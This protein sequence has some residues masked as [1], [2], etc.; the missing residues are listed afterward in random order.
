MKSFEGYLKQTVGDTYLLLAGGGIKPLSD[1]FDTTTSDGRYVKKTGDIMTGGLAI[2]P[3]TIT[4]ANP[5][6][7]IGYTSTA[8]D[9][10]ASPQVNIGYI[11]FGNTKYNCHLGLAPTDRTQF[12]K[13]G[14]FYHITT[15]C[16]FDWVTEG[17]TKLMALEC[18][19]G[20]LW[21]KRNLSA[22]GGTFSGT[23][24]GNSGSGLIL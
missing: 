1:F 10:S 17:W 12:G 21:L 23:I 7:A 5:A 2:N 4:D 9:P 14:Y 20:D 16:E 8:S 3:S 15:N 18:S 6:L 24:Y 19:T 13:I 11:K 22:V